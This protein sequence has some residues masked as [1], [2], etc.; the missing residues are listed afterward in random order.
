M[1]CIVDG[2]SMETGTKHEIFFGRVRRSISIKYLLQVPLCQY[3][4][5]QAHGQTV[6]I[7]A[8][9]GDIKTMYRKLLQ[10]TSGR[11]QEEWKRIF[12]REL[13]INYDDVNLWMNT[14]PEQESRESLEG[15]RDHIKNNMSWIMELEAILV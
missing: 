5:A 11:S 13:H 7:D 3:H 4:H 1:L 8:N 12:C 14:Y 2:C 10:S 15:I 6:Y 9:M